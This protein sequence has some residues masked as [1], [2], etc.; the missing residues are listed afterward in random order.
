MEL[1]ETMNKK[2]GELVDGDIF[3]AHG[4][5]WKK[6]DRR[7]AISFGK[8]TVTYLQLA[9]VVDFVGH[10]IWPTEARLKEVMPSEE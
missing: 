6:I 5:A 4:K 1:G 9:D 2:F 8:D 7:V 3:I 10:G